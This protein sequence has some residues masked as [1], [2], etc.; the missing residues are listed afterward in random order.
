MGNVKKNAI[1]GHVNFF[2]NSLDISN[3][4]IFHYLMSKIKKD[5]H[6]NKPLSKSLNLNRLKIYSKHQFSI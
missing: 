3:K 6:L 2:Q 1:L 5:I 4:N